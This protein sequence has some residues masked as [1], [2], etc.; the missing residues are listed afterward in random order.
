VAVAEAVLPMLSAPV[1]A[2]QI[3]HPY[4]SPRTAAPGVAPP[5]QWFP[6]AEGI[7]DQRPRQSECFYKRHHA[8]LGLLPLVKVFPAVVMN[9]DRVTYPLPRSRSIKHK[10]GLPPAVH[11]AGPYLRAENRTLVGAHPSIGQVRRHQGQDLR[12]ITLSGHHG[13]NT[14]WLQ[15]LR[16]QACQVAVEREGFSRIRRIC[17]D[18]VQ[19]F[20]EARQ[21]RLHGTMPHIYRGAVLMRR[22]FEKGR[23]VEFFLSIVNNAPILLVDCSL[24]TPQPFFYGLGCLLRDH[25]GLVNGVV[26]ETGNLRQFLIGVDLLS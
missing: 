10:Y 8:R 26:A 18:G 15:R 5:H 23:A 14:I 4:H 11:S 25:T 24:T 1:P 13:E 20:I 7:T 17:D 16:C 6:Y 9:H 21:Q 12:Q 2:A 3:P 19:F 22:R